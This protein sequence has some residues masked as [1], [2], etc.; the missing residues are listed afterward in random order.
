MAPLTKRIPRQLAHNWTKYLSFFVI[1]VLF[2]ASACGYGGT[3]FSTI[4]LSAKANQ[5]L[6]LEDGRFETNFKVD[7]DVMA[8]V[9]AKGAN[10]Y[11]MFNLQATMSLKDRDDAKLRIYKER[12]D[13]DLQFYDEGK[14]PASANEISINRNFARNNNINVGDTVEVNGKKLTVSGFTGFI[15]IQYP[16]ETNSSFMGNTLTYCVCSMTPEGYEALLD[17]GAKETFD[18]SFS[19]KDKSLD[20]ASAREDVEEDMYDVLKDENVAVASFLDVENVRSADYATDDMEGDWT[21]VLVLIILMFVV[22]AFIMNV[23]TDSTIDSESAVIGTLLASGYSRSEIARHYMAIP[24]LIS[25]VGVI[26]GNILGYTLFIDYIQGIYYSNYSL[27]PFYATFSWTM[28]LECSLVPLI[29]LLIIALFGIIRKFKYTPLQFLRHE[30]KKRRAYNNINMPEKWKFVTRFRLRVF[31]QNLGKYATLL[32]GIFL[33]TTLVVFGNLMIPSIKNY[34]EGAAKSV[35]V[36]HIYTLKAPL[37]LT[38]SEEDVA[39]WSAYD[40]LTKNVD[41]SKV[42]ED[43]LE[44]KITDYFTEKMQMPTDA[45]LDSLTAEDLGLDANYLGGYTVGEFMDLGDDMDSIDTDDDNVH[46]VNTLSNSTAAINGAEKIA[47]TTVEVTRQWSGTNEDI[48]VYGVPKDSKYWSAINLKSLTGGEIAVGAGLLDKCEVELNKEF[49]ATTDDGD[50]YKFTA[51]EIFGESASTNIYMTLDEFRRI[52][53]EDASY[54]NGYA[55]DEALNIDS[56]FLLSE[57]T[58]EDA[59]A[60]ASEMENFMSEMVGM[61]VGVAVVIY[62]ITMYLL[63]KVIIDNSARSISYMKVF[64]YRQREI[65]GLYI[66]SITITVIASLIV[67]IPAIM[68]LIDVIWKVAISRYSGN[69]LIYFDPVVIAESVVVGLVTYLV[70]ALLDIR[71]INRVSMAEALKVQE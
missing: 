26:V 17:A 27:P 65:R 58:P 30:I 63:T 12:T 3:I 60:L 43:E 52:F 6:K 53:D 34:S 20:T 21:M 69:I 15:E 18:Y 37:E 41:L 22:M 36:E 2:V 1:L 61:L 49:T 8:K 51:V 44:D 11:E 10:V 25:I 50:D 70:V 32:L 5:D 16:L 67:T 4:D 42:D 9:E 46:P 24:F 13:I 48:T 33:G 39:A 28:F 54:F 7:D 29:V 19:M 59:Q 55:S 64:G 57:T 71:H 14:A 56:T 40:K 31:L 45:A 47:V 23:I 66:R 35:P 68:A 62:F 38:G